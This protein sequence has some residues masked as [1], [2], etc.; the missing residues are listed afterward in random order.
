MIDLI[1]TGPFMDAKTCL[2]EGPGRLI[3]VQYSDDLLYKVL[4][5]RHTYSKRE[6]Q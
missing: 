2:D 5:N 6:S 1:C 4:R 3:F